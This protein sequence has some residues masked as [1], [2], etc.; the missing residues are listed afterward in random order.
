M[1]MRL[2]DAPQSPWGSPQLARAGGGEQDRGLLPP[3]SGHLVL[4][5]RAG[6]R[7]AW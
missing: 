4:A 2:E 7:G 1:L 3:R 5:A 6:R